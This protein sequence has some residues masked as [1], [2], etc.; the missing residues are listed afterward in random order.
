MYVFYTGSRR[1]PSSIKLH[2]PTTV[3]GWITRL[4]WLPSLPEFSFPFLSYISFTSNLNYFHL[5]HCLWVVLEEIQTKPG[6]LSMFKSTYTYI[7]IFHLIHNYKVR[8]AV[9]DS[10]Y[11]RTERLSNFPLMTSGKRQ[12]LG[13]TQLCF[14]SICFSSSV[15][16]RKKA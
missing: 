9:L 1:S 7:I 5:S 8:K 14:L 4:F 2:W 11:R 10:F 15:H 13:R 12:S 6:L 16:F 3:I